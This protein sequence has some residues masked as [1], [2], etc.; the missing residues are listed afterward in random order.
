MSFIFKD[1][2]RIVIMKHVNFYFLSSKI[3]IFS[4]LKIK[5]IM[6][7]NSSKGK[8]FSDAQI[9]K[10]VKL[11]FD[12]EDYDYDLLNKFKNKKEFCN[13]LRP[14]F[15]GVINENQTY[16][17]KIMKEAKNQEEK[18]ELKLKQK[19]QNI[20]INKILKEVPSFSKIS[21]H[22]NIEIKENTPLL[23]DGCEYYYCARDEVKNDYPDY[24]MDLLIEYKNEQIFYFW[25]ECP[26]ELDMS[27]DKVY[28]DYD[29][30]AEDTILEFESDFFK[31]YF[32]FEETLKI[33]SV[34]LNS[35]EIEENQERLLSRIKTEL[36]EYFQEDTSEDD[37]DN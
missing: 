7:Q 11:M 1:Q 4:F 25:Y 19:K 15:E 34:I 27:S 14:I 5:K 28:Y 10:F 32:T 2:F 13:K 35:G 16:V 24:E 22:I 31:S 18:R 23:E 20:L 30:R 21:N 3:D 37:S 36:N 12:G 17:T 6:S 29:S 26:S 8:K 33:M 9:L